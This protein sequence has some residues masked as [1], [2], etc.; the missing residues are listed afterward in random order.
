MT[1]Y[2]SDPIPVDRAS[3]RQQIDERA[4]ALMP[5]LD[6]TSPGT[7]YDFLADLF[8]TFHAEQLSTLTQMLT[9]AFRGSLEKV[10][11][12]TQRDA[13]QATATATLTRTAEDAATGERV[14]SAGTEFNVQG[15]DGQPV[16]FQ[17]VNDETFTGTDDTI[18]GV[19]VIAVL[20]GTGGNGLTVVLGPA[21]TVAWFDTL[22]LNGPT[23]GGEDAEDDDEYLNRGAD[24]RPGRAFTIVRAD[25]LARYL[26]NQP[27]V[28]RAQVVDNL[29]GD[30]STAGV[31]G[32][33]TAIPIDADGSA[34]S[35]GV[36]GALE[37]A[38]Q[39]LSVTGLEI[40]VIAPTST[41]ITVVFA[42]VA[43]VG[44]NAADVEARAEAAVLDFLDR[45]RWG[46]PDG[47]DERGW[48]DKRTVY[49]Q[50]IST[51]LN[52]VQGFA[53]HTSLTINGGTSDVVMTG[54]GALPSTSST[55]SGTVTAP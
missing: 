33:I 6:T 7:S 28:D 5:D 39:A 31:G 37:A 1:S 51:V 54:P 55:A 40:H 20:G 15:A 18:T 25:D 26:R 13:V 34:L 43:N 21:Q 10:D 27:G 32:H 35:P 52:N 46:L 17:L 22:T 53:R 9:I 47:G 12:I 38:A 29:N 36:M 50:D 30:T 8:A 19:D 44:Y 24:E 42:G 49:Y 41:T 14:V 3:I 2:L 16:A 23:S 4:L 48:E 11:R 45:S